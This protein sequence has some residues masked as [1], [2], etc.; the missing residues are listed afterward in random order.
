MAFSFLKSLF[1]S[2]K[3]HACLVINDAYLE[4]LQ[5]KQNG[6]KIELVGINKV[7]LEEGV[8]EHGAIKNESGFQSAV[9]QL[10]SDAQPQPI[11]AKHLYINI[12]FEQIYPFV[13]TFSTHSKEEHMKNSLMSLV[14]SQAPFQEDE[15]MVDF[16]KTESSK[17]ISYC[18]L[19]YPK[20][21]KRTVHESCTEMGFE[22]L[23]F[24]PE[25]VAQL[26]LAQPIE[27]DHYALL[28]WQDGRIFF[29]LF[30]DSLLFDS[31]ALKSAFDQNHKDP[32]LL[33]DECKKAIEDF[34]DSFKKSIQQYYFASFPS[35]L[36]APLQK[37]ADNENWN[38]VFLKETENQISQI[39]PEE[40]YS[41]T[42]VGM[43]FRLLKKNDG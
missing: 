13:Q 6:G 9:S 3:E 1:G 16:D 15:L 26:S 21:W 11:K 12:P 30:F 42:L 7:A 22:E 29:S 4:G 23:H 40:N 31:F 10:F 24:I 17:R 14:E 8:V 2:E 5:F 34:E 25:S 32:A 43:A 20:N 27:T 39:I 38:D 35:S 19:V 28:S 18:A 36:R 37:V 41:T 33:V